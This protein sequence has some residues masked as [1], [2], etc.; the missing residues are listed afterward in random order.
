VNFGEFTL[1]AFAHNL[2]DKR[3]LTSVAGFNAV[4]AGPAGAA[5]AAAIRP[6][7]IGLTL[8]ANLRP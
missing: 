6:R 5:S 1:E 3:G 2:F 7:T 8:T 4:T